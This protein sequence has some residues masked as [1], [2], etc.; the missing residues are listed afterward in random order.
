MKRTLDELLHETLIATDIPPEE[1]N[2][3]LIEKSVKTKAASGDKSVKTKVV[4]ADSLSGKRHWKL[5][6][7]AAAV[8]VLILVT[9]CGVYA[10][11][12][13]LAQ[14]QIT[15]ISDETEFMENN[16][17]DT[18]HY[19]EFLGEDIDFTN[20]AVSDRADNLR[21]S[22]DFAGTVTEG[23]LEDSWSLKTEEKADGAVEV[24]YVYPDLSTAFEDQKIE[25][26]LSYIEEH[27]PT[28]WGEKA[29]QLWYD[30]EDAGS[31]SSGAFFASYRNEEKQAVSVQYEISKVANEEDY[32]FV[33]NYDSVSTYTTSDG[34]TLTIYSQTA[35][36]GYPITYA[37]LITEYSD[38]TL[39]LRGSFTEKESHAIYDSLN[40]SSICET[41]EQ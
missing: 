29:C 40:L 22:P 20:S 37:R 33:A 38:F 13:I 30:S 12:R 1:L 17:E 3:K 2:R 31:Y 35:G 26:N 6:Q 15:I 16:T 23:T 24:E 41:T 7:T 9:G 8:A 19:E 11:E 18:I 14:K 28:L 32:M 34:V 36:S 25:L 4:P 21:N 10:A 39:T 27:Y 5:A